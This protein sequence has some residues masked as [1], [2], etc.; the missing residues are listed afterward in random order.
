MKNSELYDLNY[1][2]CD[3][4]LDA[5]AYV[6][7]KSINHPERNYE[8]I[9][10]ITSNTLSCCILKTK[11]HRIFTLHFDFCEKID[12]RKKTFTNIDGEILKIFKIT[13][14]IRSKKPSFNDY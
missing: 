2:Q 13:T 4:Y 3:E 6:E 11:K 8:G 9:A 7:Y 10:K 1:L 14:K 5:D 12:N